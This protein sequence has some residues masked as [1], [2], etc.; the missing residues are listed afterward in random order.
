MNS[1]NSADFDIAAHWPVPGE[2]TF[3]TILEVRAR[4]DPDHPLCVWDGGQLTVGELYDRST[5]LANALLDMSIGKDDVVALMLDQHA[6]HIIALYACAQIGVPRTSINVNAKG[7]YLSLL[8][9]DARPAVLIAEA[10]YHPL[11]EQA[12][13]ETNIAHLIWHDQSGQS[14]LDRMIEQG[15]TTLPFLSAEPDDPLV[16]NYTSGTTGAPKKFSRSDRVLQIGSIG[17]L[18][19]GKLEA[20]D[21]LLFWEPLY[22]GAGHQTVF[23]AI[24]EKLTLALVPSFSAS[25][26][27]DQARQFNAT[28]IH[29]IGGVLPILLKQ[30]IR[31]ND[32]DH[33]VTIAWGRRVSR[34]R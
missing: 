20:G 18:L 29:Y 28:K 24:M 10:A 12:L 21:T 3:R 33:A 14:E 31:D 15:A 2:E 27:W 32:L 25:R 5:K 4:T 13:S 30:P 1:E 19:I 17:C 8:L 7:D 9:A 16:I 6:E 23:A 11:L 34:G 26:F 22:H